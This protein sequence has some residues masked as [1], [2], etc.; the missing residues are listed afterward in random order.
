M[1]QDQKTKSNDVE[2]E[3][4]VITESIKTID[5]AESP[6][7]I[8]QDPNDIEVKVN[9]V[10]ASIHNTIL[11]FLWGWVFFCFLYSFLVFSI[12]NYVCFLLAFV[13]LLNTFFNFVPFIKGKGEKPKKLYVITKTIETILIVAGLV[14]TFL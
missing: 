7:Q 13:F 9:S 8:Q 5:E 6:E 12:E 4:E 2:V 10:G 14:S 1:E 3:V 11:F